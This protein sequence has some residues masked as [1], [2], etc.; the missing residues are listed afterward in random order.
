[1]KKLLLFLIPCLN[2]SQSN[3]DCTNTSVI[4]DYGSNQEEVSWFIQ[5]ASG[6]N[7]ASGGAPYSGEVC[8]E[9]D[10]Y[11]LVLMDS[12]GDGWNNNVLVIGDQFF[13]GPSLNYTYDNFCVEDQEGGDIVCG[14]TDPSAC[15]YNVEANE[16]DGSCEYLVN[17][18]GECD[19]GGSFCIDP[20]ACNYYNVMTQQGPPWEFGLLDWWDCQYVGDFGCYIWEETFGQ[21]IFPGEPDYFAWNENCECVL[22]SCLDETACNYD[23]GPV[24]IIPA[25]NNLIEA[26][27][28]TYI[29]LDCA[30]PG[31]SC[32]WINENLYSDYDVFYGGPWEF[33]FGIFT[34]L[35]DAVLYSGVYN[36]DCECICNITTPIPIWY[37]N[38]TGDFFVDTITSCN[39]NISILESIQQKSLLKTIDIVGRETTN[40]GFQLQIY[41][42][43]SVEKKYLVK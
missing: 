26:F 8:L 28:P 18:F 7:V 2:F 41:D 34:D 32:L 37:S 31:D 15:N 30:Q 20:N 5:D 14:C 6:E 43:G 9:N 33:E 39:E 4:C 24:G 22:S 42:D 12:G 38:E 40:R 11:I 27:L 29:G 35:E 17:E 25:F 13:T 1:M 19:E 16:N 21:Y 23:A 36:N 3:C 10:C